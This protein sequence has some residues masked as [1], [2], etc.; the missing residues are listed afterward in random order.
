[1]GRCRTLTRPENGCH[2]RLVAGTRRTRHAV[3]AGQQLL[4]PSALDA[5]EDVTSRVTQGLELSQL[6][7][8]V[9]PSSQPCQGLAPSLTSVAY[10]ATGVRADGHTAVEARALLEACGARL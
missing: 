10:S 8:A 5:A 4:Q 6:Y 9:L 7:D 1:M 2:R 3:R